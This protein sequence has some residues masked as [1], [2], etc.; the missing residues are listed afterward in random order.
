LCR[1]TPILFYSSRLLR[2]FPTKNSM[3]RYRVACAMDINR[4]WRGHVG[5]KAAREQVRLNLIAATSR[6]LQAVLRRAVLHERY[7]VLLEDMY[8][9]EKIRTIQR[10][11][12]GGIARCRVREMKRAIEMVISTRVLQRVYR[13]HV[14][15]RVA[16]GVIYEKAKLEASLLIQRGMRGMHG[17]AKARQAREAVQM[18][19][20]A[21]VLQK[22]YQ[23][24][25]SKLPKST[26]NGEHHLSPWYLHCGFASSCFSSGR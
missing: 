18:D 7:I 5:R 3:G 10:F 6:P 20:A 4:A 19:V 23:V 17:R 1:C 16:N 14:G 22:G 2:C 24:T 25:K 9:D 26:Q 12:Q 8:L 13:G 15:R 11:W 21:K